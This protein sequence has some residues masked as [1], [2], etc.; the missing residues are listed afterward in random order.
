MYVT[1]GSYKS[2]LVWEAIAG[3]FVNLL[4]GCVW[5]VGMWAVYEFIEFNVLASMFYFTV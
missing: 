5:P 1:S 4:T 2:K 3:A